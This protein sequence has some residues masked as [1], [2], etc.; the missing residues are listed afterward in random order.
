LLVLEDR[1]LPSSFV[2]T[3]LADSGAGSL[4]QAVLDANS[5]GGD[6]T[7]TFA[8]NGTVTLQSALP[9]LS[10]NVDI[11]GPGPS[12]L[13]VQRSPAPGTPAFSI[14]TVDSYA[15]VRVAGVMLTNGSG[16][17]GGGIFND[18]GTLTVDNCFVIANTAWRGGGILNFGTLT[19]SASILSTN[20]ATNNGGGI[21]NFG[22]L[23]LDHSILSGNSGDNGGAVY[24]FG[25]GSLALSYSTLSYNSANF[26][27]A[28]A[29]NG[30]TVTVDSST[31]AYNTALSGGGIANP[32][33]GTVVVRDSTLA[34]NTATSAAGGGIANDSGA[35]LT[36]SNSTIAGNAAASGGGIANG[37]T[38]TT[39]DT[40]LAGNLAPAGA[41]LSGNLGSLGHNL[42][43]NTTGG[44]GFDATDLLNVDP[45]LGPLQYNGGPTQTMALLPGSPALDA[46]DNTGVPAFDQRGPGF[47]RI[48]NGVI[49]V[50][51]FEAQGPA[52]NVPNHALP[53]S[54]DQTLTATAILSIQDSFATNRTL[55]TTP[56]ERVAWLQASSQV[57]TAVDRL[58]ATANRHQESAV[59]GTRMATHS[60]VPVPWTDTFDLERLPR[61]G[62]AQG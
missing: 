26:G 61:E 57:P 33:G 55:G 16:F 42:I 30:G 59:R 40:I 11:E 53:F 22:P 8:V 13:S 23:A 45:R 6:N 58:F 12:S 52:S 28:I 38:L 46:G 36:V 20:V 62:D 51:A 32:Y 4:R 15:T 17:Y 41:D 37:G 39:F 21:A 54:P 47:A 24:N 56:E 60:L 10:S 29:D 7:I 2:V 25:A 48:V 19:V 1:T 34:G 9:D 49:D 50:G 44:S 43:G 14:L 35:V 27:G 18:G 3:S 31:V 5:A